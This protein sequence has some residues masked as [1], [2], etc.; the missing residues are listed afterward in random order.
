V[1]V[2]ELRKLRISDENITGDFDPVE[3]SLVSGSH[4]PSLLFVGDG[5]PIIGAR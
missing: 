5:K 3:L 2:P 4:L 1:A